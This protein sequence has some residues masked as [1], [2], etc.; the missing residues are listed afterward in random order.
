MAT[1]LTFIHFIITIIIIYV[2]CLASHLKVIRISTLETILKYN[3]KCEPWV[4]MLSK[5]VVGGEI[6]SSE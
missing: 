3:D 2:K 4:T 1:H 5:G 6:S